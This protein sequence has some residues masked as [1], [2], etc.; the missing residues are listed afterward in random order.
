[1]EN[2]KENGN[3]GKKSVTVVEVITSLHA[4]AQHYEGLAKALEIESGLRPAIN[5]GAGIALPG[6]IDAQALRTFMKD[7]AFRA[8]DLA[9]HFNVSREEVEK[10]TTQENGFKTGRQAWITAE[11]EAQP[12][13]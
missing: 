13:A 4:K 2:G 5:V 1:M 12:V 3:G 8:V 10:I 11:K 7:K 6:H 9:K